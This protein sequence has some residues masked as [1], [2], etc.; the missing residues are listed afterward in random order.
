VETNTYQQTTV[1]GW[2]NP[3]VNN[4]R[5]DDSLGHATVSRPREQMITSLPEITPP[6]KVPCYEQSMRLLQL[7]PLF[8]ALQTWNS[9]PVRHKKMGHK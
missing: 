1:G 5:G 2:R 6:S 8:N 7:P 9:K 4:P 3:A